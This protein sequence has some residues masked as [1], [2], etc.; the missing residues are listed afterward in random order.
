MA[1]NIRDTGG[2]IRMQENI[3]KNGIAAGNAFLLGDKNGITFENYIGEADA[4]KHT[5]IAENTIFHMYSMT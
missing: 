5:P 4:D 2:L 3:I 1:V